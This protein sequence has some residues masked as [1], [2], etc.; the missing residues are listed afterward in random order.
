MEDFCMN[1]MVLKNIVI[2]FVFISVYY[3]CTFEVDASDWFTINIPD[4]INLIANNNTID[5]LTVRYGHFIV[6]KTGGRIRFFG[7]TVGWEYPN[8]SRSAID[9][10]VEYMKSVGINAVRIHYPGLWNKK[11][12][13]FNANAIEKFDYLT[14]SLSKHQIYYVIYS[15]NMIYLNY[16]GENGLSFRESRGVSLM[17]SSD[18]RGIKIF[19]DSLMNHENIYNGIK[20]KN[21]SALA[22]IIL[23]NENSV[24]KLLRMKN[25]KDII[26][27]YWYKDAPK[28]GFEST[29]FPQKGN[30]SKDLLE[31]AAKED[32]SSFVNMRKFLRNIGVKVPI[33]FTNNPFSYYTQKILSKVVDFECVHN[34][35][36][37]ASGYKD[38]IFRT[39]SPFVFK[40]NVPGEFP[41]RMLSVNYYKKPVI[42]DEWN[43]GYPSIYRVEPT[44]LI[45]I[46]C[47]SYD[48]D[49]EFFFLMFAHS[50][51][52]ENPHK[53]QRYYLTSL[54]APYSIQTLFF[55]SLSLAYRNG[56]ISVLKD[57]L[58]VM[59]NDSNSKI[60]KRYQFRY[61]PLTGVK[62]LLYYL[63]R[64]IIKFSN[65][66][67]ISS[68]DLEIPKDGIIVN[69][70]IYWDYKCGVFS[71]VSNRF[72]VYSGD[73]R[74]NFH[75]RQYSLSS[76]NNRIYLSL[77]PLDGKEI[78]ESD[79][80][81]ITVAENALHKGDNKLINEYILNKYI[82]YYPSKE[83]QMSKM[84]TP[85]SVELNNVKFSL[86][87][88]R[89]KRGGL[90]LYAL[91]PNGKVKFISKVRKQ[92]GKICFSTNSGKYGTCYFLLKNR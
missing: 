5:W 88:P 16:K 54:E 71:F 59:V 31:F 4:K 91:Y 28:F 17:N 6:K 77:L 65:K 63:K 62:G 80:L 55:P 7:T 64:I 78:K 73:I 14:Y 90:L 51:Y 29:D 84:R 67:N 20:Y 92:G 19:W 22:F 27:R 47:G 45:P 74:R 66:S 72:F 42:V 53:K 15:V 23:T 87:V 61:N 60:G 50:N 39:H 8:A 36:N 37:Y 46:L 48:Y 86:K 34:Y 38:K 21:D 85:S 9:K 3:V 57:S 49:G 56:Y 32:S 25:G 58:V 13:K 82:A 35:A 41:T 33:T 12:K 11:E 76:R 40:N 69:D 83:R 26:K 89:K 18:I 52:I 30:Y 70:N 2:M 10:S 79:S 1:K 43:M 68:I 44:I 24:D 75:F 81:L